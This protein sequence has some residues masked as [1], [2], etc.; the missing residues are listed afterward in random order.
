MFYFFLSFPG[1]AFQLPVLI[2]RTSP[3]FQTFSCPSSFPPVPPTA[4]P[5]LLLPYLF[6]LRLTLSFP[7]P[8]LVLPSGRSGL[9]A[10]YLSVKALVPQMP[11]LLKSLFPAREDKK[12]PLR[13]SPHSLQV[14]CTYPSDLLTLVKISHSF[15]LSCNP[16][17]SFPIF[18]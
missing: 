18:L 10:S 17:E 8:S 7:P 16:I 2:S 4:P 15:F 6:F 13:P 14:G 3:T 1:L 11:K 5:F 9:A 12:E